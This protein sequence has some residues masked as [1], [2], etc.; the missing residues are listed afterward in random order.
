MNDCQICGAEN[1]ECCEAPD[2]QQPE[3]PKDCLGGNC[4]C[5]ENW[6][7]ECINCGAYC[8]CDV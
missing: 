2:L 7:V 3:H 4:L 1:N 5:D 6:S 8:G